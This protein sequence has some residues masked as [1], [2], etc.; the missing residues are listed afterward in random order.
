MIN[1]KYKYESEDPDDRIREALRKGYF[2]N[3]V[4]EINKIKKP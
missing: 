3:V 2:S 1:T 4:D